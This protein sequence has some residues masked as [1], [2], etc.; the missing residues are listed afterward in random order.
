[1]FTSGVV[2]TIQT[3]LDAIAN[4]SCSEGYDLVGDAMRTCQE[5]GQWNGAEPTCMC[6]YLL[7]LSYTSADEVHCKIFYSFSN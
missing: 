3:G 2:T 1:M 4:Y 7:I 6:K 5:T